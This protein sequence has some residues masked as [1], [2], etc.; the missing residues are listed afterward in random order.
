MALMPQGFM[1]LTPNTMARRVS[2][3]AVLVSRLSVI[4]LLTKR[5]TDH[6]FDIHRAE[7]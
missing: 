7:V 6:G 3:L 2:S 5:G 4:P 1:A